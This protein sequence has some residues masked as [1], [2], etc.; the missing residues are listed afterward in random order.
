MAKIA[1]AGGKMATVDDE[2][3]QKLSSFSWYFDGRYVA[4]KPRRKTMFMHNIVMPAPPGMFVDHRSRDTLDNRRANLRHSTRS[5]NN[6]NR[7]N[8]GDIKY[9]GVS[10]NGDRFRVRCGS[11]YL[12]T[13]DTAEEAAREYDKEALLQHRD[14][15]VLN[16]PAEGQ[17]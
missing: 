12:G 15:A 5:Q 14:F 10:R 16:F 6:A 13:F 2:D 11:K 17:V 1:I 7:K 4:T 8:W 9:K 3:F